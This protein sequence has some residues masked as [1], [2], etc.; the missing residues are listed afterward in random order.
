MLFVPI[1]FYNDF[2]YS[3][4]QIML[5]YIISS[6]VA[7]VS[8]I[9]AIEIIDKEGTKIGILSWFI[10]LILYF[11]VWA[12]FPIEWSVIYLL[13]ILNW[14]FTGFFW[15]SF[16][17]NMST[18]AD[19]KKEGSTIAKVNIMITVI[20]AISPLIWW[21]IIQN[22]GYKY[23]FVV[24]IVIVLF[25]I[26]ILFHSS[27]KHKT[28][29]ITRKKILKHYIS[30]YKKATEKNFIISIASLWHLGFSGAIF[31]PLFIYLIIPNFSK[32]GFVS[33]LTS[34][35]TVILLYFIGHKLDKWEDKKIIKTSASIQLLN[36]I[37]WGIFAFLNIFNGIF[38]TVIDTIHRFTHSI[39]VTTLDKNFYTANEESDPLFKVLSHE[40]SIHASRI[41]FLGIFILANIWIPDKIMIHIAIATVI[42]IIPLQW[43]VL[44][45]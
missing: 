13:A 21:L 30:H 23:I 37:S 6:W 12:I 28:K 7:I 18:H 26:W 40:I 10:S 22:F 1:L 3:F 17:Y 24:S 32:I 16:H 36:W 2:W 15:S 8:N 39:N 35:I 25:A 41:I 4:S 31:W 44:K 14:L 27:Q 11:T 33:T 38:I 42:I 43:I 5:F 19:K 45:K 34:I 9:L 29:N 20:A